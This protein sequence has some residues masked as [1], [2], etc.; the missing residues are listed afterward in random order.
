MKVLLQCA[1]ISFY[2]EKNL[3]GKKWNKIKEKKNYVVNLKKNY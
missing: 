1:S 2:W 3:T